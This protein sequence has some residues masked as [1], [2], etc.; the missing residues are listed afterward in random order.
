MIVGDLLSYNHT[1]L[2]IAHGATHS[3]YI[4][5]L[6]TYISISYPKS[7]ISDTSLSVG[8]SCHIFLTT[9]LILSHYYIR[10]KHISKA[11][12]L[13][14]V[15]RMASFTAPGVVSIREISREDDEGR[16]DAYTHTPAYTTCR[17]LGSL[18][19]VVE[20]KES[21]NCH[22]SCGDGLQNVW[23]H[24]CVGLL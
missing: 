6:L 14:P 21:E 5:P 11:T 22:Q 3:T 19:A 4:F 10:K 18:L 17:S 9:C 13:C 12:D 8:T 24:L 20:H 2:H 23:V 7:N 15:P 1:F 16:N